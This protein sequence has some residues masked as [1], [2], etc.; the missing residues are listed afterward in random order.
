MK[1]S[2]PDYFINE[3]ST[4]A[5]FVQAA[6]ELGYYGYDTKP[7]KGLL[8]IKNSKGYLNKLFVPADAQ[9]KFD[10]AL[11]RKLKRF[12]ANTPQRMMFIYGEYDP[13][14]AVKVNEPKSKNIVLFVEP[15]GSHKARISTLPPQMRE[16]AVE[17]LKMW[18]S[19]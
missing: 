7:F 8:S 13:W 19:E 4:T 16:K 11:Y 10:R 3:S 17:T 9:F 12:I 14:S 6:R 1:I 5:F 2:S 15:K 18:L